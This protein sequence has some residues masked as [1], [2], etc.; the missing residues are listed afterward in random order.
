M[1]PRTYRGTLHREILFNNV[2]QSLWLSLSS[3][4]VPKEERLARGNEASVVQYK[5]LVTLP[6]SSYNGLVAGLGPTTELANQCCALVLLISALGWC[7]GVGAPAPRPR[8]ASPG[9]PLCSP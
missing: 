4:R 5:G 9:E 7:R 2:L 8:P 3:R 1:A 6:F